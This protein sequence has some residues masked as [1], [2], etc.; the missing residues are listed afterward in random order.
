MHEQSN[1]DTDIFTWPEAS[2]IRSF[3]SDSER[4]QVDLGALSDPG[5]VRPNNE[6]HFL[7]TRFDRSMRTLI[8]NLPPGHVPEHY[9]ETAYGMLVADGLGG[10]AAG[11][12][13]SR[14]AV[15][16][17]VDLVLQTPDWILR[18]DEESLRQVR[19]R[20][21]RRFQQVQEALRGQ[22]R[23]D[24]SLAGMGTTM[25]LVCSLGADLL[26]IHVG[27]SRA[28]LLRQGKLHRL[29]CD[30]TMAQSLADAGVI[31][32]QDVATH[33]LRHVLTNVL[34]GRD[35]RVRVDWRELRLVDGDQVLL[36]TD[37]LT[38]MVPHETIIEVLRSAGTA[39]DACRTLVELALDAG[40][41]DN[42]TVVLGRFHILEDGK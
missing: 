29:T 3:K 12:V 1:V 23:E 42:I 11:E 35:G 36:C 19:K 14:L 17:L 18:L 4:V 5:K 10:E 21:E 20:M 28:Y 38:D 33:P 34:G 16:V 7:V 6:D 9:G 22:A 2:D 31:S 41:K 39:A 15:S 8:T 40:G 32:P 24:P 30:H 37:G 13:A 27:D 25:T 26:L